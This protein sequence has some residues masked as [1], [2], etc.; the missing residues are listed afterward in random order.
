LKFSSPPWS[1]T[2]RTK[3]LSR[4]QKKPGIGRRVSAVMRFALSKGSSAFFTQMFSVPFHG[5]RNAMYRPS[6]E[7]VALLIS[8]LPKKSWRSISGT[9]DV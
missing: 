2:K 6:G 7:S 3:R 8:G 5:L 9:L 4:L 1:C